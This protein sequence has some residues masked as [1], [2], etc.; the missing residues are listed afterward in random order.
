MPD[1]TLRAG[2]DAG[3]TV[4]PAPPPLLDGERAE[5]LEALQDYAHDYDELGRIAGIAASM[6]ESGEDGRASSASFLTRLAGAL[7][8]SAAALRQGLPLMPNHSLHEEGDAA[9]RIETAR[10]EMVAAAVEAG[11]RSARWSPRRTS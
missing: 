9:A 10:A 7:G 6:E 3:G 4:P 5:R 8:A 11:T 2:R 1:L